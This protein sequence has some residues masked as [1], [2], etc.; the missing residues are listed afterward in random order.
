MLGLVVVSG[1][2]LAEYKKDEKDHDRSA[3]YETSTFEIAGAVCFYVLLWDA[4]LTVWIAIGCNHLDCVWI[5]VAPGVGGFGH[6]Y[7][8]CEVL[9][10]EA[11]IYYRYSQVRLNF[12]VA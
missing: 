10:Q 1:I 4:K 11:D 8:A 3:G 2:T 9:Y 12:R 7:R 5:C 6:L